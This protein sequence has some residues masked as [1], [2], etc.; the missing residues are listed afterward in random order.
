MAVL[1][2]RGDVRGAADSLKRE[3]IFLH[4]E[5]PAPHDPQG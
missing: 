3:F 5:D 4:Q 2:K 1:N